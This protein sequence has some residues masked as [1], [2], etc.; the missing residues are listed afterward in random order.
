MK[1]K[2]RMMDEVAI[3]DVSGKLLGGPPSSQELKD[4]IYQ[5]LDEGVK[6]FVIDLGDVKRMNSSGL[7]ILIQML[8]S[9]RKGDGELKL[10]SVN[11]TMEGILVLTKL[12]S[13]FEIY[14]TAE[15]AAQ[16]FSTPA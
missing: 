4:Q 16:S 8:A 14:K 1:I 9:I 5:L 2:K 10:S 12:N 7:G 13:I 11:E 15:G 6:K 3:L